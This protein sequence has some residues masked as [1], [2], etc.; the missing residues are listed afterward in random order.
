MEESA[1]IQEITS[2]HVSVGHS[3]KPSVS[4]QIAALR[5][6]LLGKI[7]GNA[8]TWF[9]KV[10]K[11]TLIFAPFHLWFIYNN[12]IAGRDSTCR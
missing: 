10:S 8:G 3:S 4:T 1:V 7:E 5:R 2:V 12:G 9:E 11:V 6:L